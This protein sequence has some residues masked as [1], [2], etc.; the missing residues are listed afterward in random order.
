MF[1]PE[2]RA[3]YRD[4]I[5]QCAHCEVPLVAELAKEDAF[6]SP[7]AMARALEGR[8]LVN[9]IV[10]SHVPLL[11]A[12]GLLAKQR[13]LSVIAGE[14]E[15]VEA[16]MHARF[17]LKVATEDLGRMR[18][19]LQEKWQEGLEREGLSLEA[20]PEKVEANACPACGTEVP[21]STTECPDCGL[22]LGDPAGGE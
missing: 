14:S 16:A 12:Q 9:V 19:I 11:E 3:E 15:E 18:E 13:L 10:G 6:S 21:D 17:Y 8:E 5:A 4:G 1:C 7:E 2:C 20:A 22:F